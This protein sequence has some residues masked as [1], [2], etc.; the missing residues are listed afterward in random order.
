MLEQLPTPSQVGKTKVGGIDLKQGSHALGGGGGDCPG[1]PAGRIHGL[2]SGLLA[3]VRNVSKSAG[4]TPA[5]S[6]GLDVSRHAGAVAGG[7]TPTREV[8]E[9]RV[10]YKAGYPPAPSAGTGSVERDSCL[11]S[12]LT[13]WTTR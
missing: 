12:S 7:G 5:G 1:S 3:P 10:G 6:A 11:V 2:R 13:D 8:Q 4:I 9:Q